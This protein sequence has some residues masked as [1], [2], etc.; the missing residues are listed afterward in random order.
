MG[1]K[2]TKRIELICIGVFVAIIASFASIQIYRAVVNSDWYNEMQTQRSFQQ[3]VKQVNDVDNI[4]Y[5]K[6]YSKIDGVGEEKLFY[7]VPAELFDD[8]SS[9][10]YDRIEDINELIEII[11]QNFVTVFY[12]N[13]NPTSFYIT[14]DGE[15]Y[16]ETSLKIECPSLLEWYNNNK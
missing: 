1:D 7:D 13:G 4:D 15:I 6:I 8:I 11:T 16:W 12:K 5:I 14:D 10:S 9:K 3:I 2:R